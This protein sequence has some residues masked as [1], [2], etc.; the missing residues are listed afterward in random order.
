MPGLNSDALKAWLRASAPPGLAAL[1]VGAAGTSRGKEKLAPSAGVEHDGPAQSRSAQPPLRPPPPKQLGAV[2]PARLCSALADSRCAW[3]RGARSGPLTAPAAPPSPRF[4]GGEKS[5]G[6]RTRR[7]E[8]ETLHRARRPV[9]AA[10]HFERTTAHRPRH[11]NQRPPGWTLAGR[12]LACALPGMPPTARHGARQPAGS[13]ECADCHAP[14]YAVGGM[15]GSAHAETKSPA[16]TGD[17]LYHAC[18]APGRHSVSDSAPFRS[19]APGG[20]SPAQHALIYS[21]R[22]KSL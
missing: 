20:S 14:C 2:A 1:R 13:R 8:W 22:C 15:P 6:S 19:E 12:E 11:D 17:G 18:S 3:G 10:S 4:G 16:R 9:L 7:K 5:A 21:V